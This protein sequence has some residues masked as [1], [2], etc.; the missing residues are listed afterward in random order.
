MGRTGKEIHLNYWL[1]GN[2]GLRVSQASLGTMTFGGDWGWGAALAAMGKGAEARP[3]FEK[4]LELDPENAWA[5]YDLACLDALKGN[6]DAAFSDLNR[7]ADCGLRSLTHMEQ[8]EDLKGVRQD[9]RWKEIHRRIPK[10][11]KN[12]AQK[13][14]V[15]QSEGGQTVQ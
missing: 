3:V 5:N 11:P 13:C 8:D 6:P 10:R 4:V 12:R 1:L 2:S 9:P 14:L 7:A 15:F